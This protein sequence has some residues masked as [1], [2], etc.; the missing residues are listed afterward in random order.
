MNG[1][2]MNDFDDL[3]NIKKYQVFIMVCDRNFYGK[4]KDSIK[5]DLVKK[6]IL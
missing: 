5:I 2:T 1:S 3:Q 6:L 4:Y